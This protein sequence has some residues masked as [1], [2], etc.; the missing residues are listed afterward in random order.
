LPWW[1]KALFLFVYPVSITYGIWV[2]WKDRRYSQNTRV[3]L[4]ALGVV[5]F[6]VLLMSS[7]R[8]SSAPEPT[9]GNAPAPASIAAPAPQQ[10]A[11]APAVSEPVPSPEPEP[12]ESYTVA[13]QEYALEAVAINTEVA[14]ALGELSSTLQ[15]DPTGVFTDEDVRMGVIVQMAVVKTGY[16]RIKALTP[17][18]RMAPSH[19][20]LLEAMRLYD[21]SMDNLAAGIDDMDTAKIEKA[22]ELMTRGAAKME[23]A[24]KKIEVLTN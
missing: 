1:G 14:E 19:E 13:E 5:L 10:S 15:D 22:S 24:T 11:P 7:S 3:V 17:P 21:K 23:S 6:A 9:A 2:M 18:A 4:T 20:D 16:E 8:Q 12:T